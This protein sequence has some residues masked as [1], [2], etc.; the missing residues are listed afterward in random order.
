PAP[1][2]SRSKLRHRIFLFL[3]SYSCARDY[4]HLNCATQDSTGCRDG[5]SLG[6]IAHRHVK[7]GLRLANFDDD[8]IP[9]DAPLSL[10]KHGHENAL[11]VVV[12]SLENGRLNASDV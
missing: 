4:S 5:H 3:R 7:N 2:G 6:V 9:M 1:S 12:Q 11:I 10:G 8:L